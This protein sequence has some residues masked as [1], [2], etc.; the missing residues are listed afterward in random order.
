[1]Q[2]CVDNTATC[3]WLTELAV[4]HLIGAALSGL[5]GHLYL[6]LYEEKNSLKTMWQYG[7]Q[8]KNEQNSQ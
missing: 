1:M 7:T 8:E 2:K 4:L 6:F 3:N 5:S